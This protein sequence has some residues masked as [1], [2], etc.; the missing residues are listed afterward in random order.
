MNKSFI[1]RINDLKSYVR[2]KK[3]GMKICFHC[4]EVDDF[5]NN[6][7]LIELFKTEIGINNIIG[8][9]YKG[10]L[11]VKR[12]NNDEYNN[13]IS[14]INNNN[15]VNKEFNDLIISYCNNAVVNLSGCGSSEIITTLILYYTKIYFEIP[16]SEKDEE[17]KKGTKWD[18]IRKKWFI[19]YTN[20]NLEYFICRYKITDETYKY[21]DEYIK[22]KTKTL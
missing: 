7:K 12:L 5:K 16:Y 11:Y 10:G 17:K 14:F 8:I 4:E 21:I 3:N 15:K 9:G 6:I 13:Y 2:T 20:E 19:Y 18:I 22:T 1:D